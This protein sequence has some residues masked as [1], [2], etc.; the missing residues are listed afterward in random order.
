MFLHAFKAVI[1]HPA[2]GATLELE[3]P[4]PVELDRFLTVLDTGEASRAQ[5]V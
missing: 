3:A 5:E 4:L 2:S 1:V